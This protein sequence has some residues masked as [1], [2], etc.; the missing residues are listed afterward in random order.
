MKEMSW[1]VSLDFFPSY[2]MSD[3]HH[4]HYYYCIIVINFKAVPTVE[5]LFGCTGSFM[6]GIG[7][8]SIV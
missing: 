2:L 3:H 8:I 6:C 4:H 1:Y 7:N 5:L